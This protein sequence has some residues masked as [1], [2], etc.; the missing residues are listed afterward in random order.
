MDAISP[1]NLNMNPVYGGVECIMDHRD[2]HG[3]VRFGYS[4]NFASNC[5][6][7]F[8]LVWFGA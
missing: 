6:V 7:F 3:P 5:I 4:S 8:G 2:G 1:I